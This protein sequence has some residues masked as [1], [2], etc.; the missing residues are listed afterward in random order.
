MKDSR[1]SG[2]RQSF[3][4]AG[5]EIDTVDGCGR[6]NGPNEQPSLDQAVDSEGVKG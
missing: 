6:D 5:E 2:F 1:F 3:R 4:F